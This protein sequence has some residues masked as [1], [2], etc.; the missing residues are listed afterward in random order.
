VIEQLSP[1][2]AKSWGRQMRRWAGWRYWRE[3][4]TDKEIPRTS[5]TWITWWHQ[6]TEVWQLKQRTGK[7]VFHKTGSSC[8]KGLGA[9]LTCLPGVLLSPEPETLNTK[10]VLGCEMQ[11]RQPCIT[12]CSAAGLVAW[13]LHHEKCW[14]RSLPTDGNP[15]NLNA[16]NRLSTRSLHSLELFSPVDL[17]S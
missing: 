14:L 6:E 2:A 16:S 7:V 17:V 3:W 12:G 5:K 8:L 13:V 4:R 1:I 15:V 9:H 10:P 11:T